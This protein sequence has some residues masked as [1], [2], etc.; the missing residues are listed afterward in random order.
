M[1]GNIKPFNIVVIAIFTLFDKVIRTRRKFEFEIALKQW[2]Y[3][4]IANK[5]IV[6]N[7]VWNLKA[8]SKV[9]LQLNLY[10]LIAYVYI[11]CFSSSV[12]FV[13]SWT[14]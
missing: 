5:L 2:E 4:T 8:G 12:N 7:S 6:F 10:E 13:H 11:I 14:Y 1:L 9:V 3:N